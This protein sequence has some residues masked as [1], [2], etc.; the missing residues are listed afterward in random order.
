[1]LLSAGKNTMNWNFYGKSEVSDSDSKS[2]KSS[3]SEL[4]LAYQKVT[5]HSGSLFLL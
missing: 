4:G 1:M 2:F 3:A 5:I